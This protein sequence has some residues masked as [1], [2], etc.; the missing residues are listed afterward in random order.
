MK[1]KNLAIFMD[2][3]NEVTP[4]G[5]QGMN[6]FQRSFWVPVDTGL[7]KLLLHYGV[8]VRKSIVLD[9]NSYKQKMPRQF[10]GGEQPIYFAPIIKNELINK[11]AGYLRNIK[12]LVVIKA[13]PVE[14]QDDTLTDSGITSAVLF[15]S[16]ERSW[17]MKERINLDPIM[18][19]PPHNEEEF[20]S[21]PLAYMLEGPFPSYFADRP[22]PEKNNEDKH[23]DDSSEED[24]GKGKTEAGID[25]SA[26]KSEGITVRK[27]KGAK[28]FLI[29]TSEILKDNVIDNEGN[30]P[31]AQF[32]MNVIDYLNNRED[33]AVMRSKTQRFNPLTEISPAARTTIKSANIAG[34]PV[35]VI[36]AGVIVWGRRTSRKRMIQRIFSK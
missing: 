14:V 6:Q 5:Q 10:G 9:E 19:K 34:L 32:V 27:G 20:R 17:E 25:M 35:L 1:G 31:N 30:T 26:I 36:I 33:I 7:E 13:S 3:F 2:S 21:I 29:G 8:S 15:S 23:Q 24:E 12:G 18:L 16:S 4:Q 22:I 28:I 11:D